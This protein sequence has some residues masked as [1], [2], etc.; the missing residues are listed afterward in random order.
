MATLFPAVSFHRRHC[1]AAWTSESGAPGAEQT[2]GGGREFC[3]E[4]RSRLIAVSATDFVL[5]TP[6]AIGFHRST[7]N[8]WERRRMKTKDYYAILGVSRNE[9]ANGIKAAFRRLAKSHHPD[10]AG[11][12]KT[13]E[14]Q[15]I[16]EA[17]C[18]L[19][20]PE[21]RRHYD[22]V[23]DAAK[24]SEDLRV[25]R[26]NHV[27]LRPSRGRRT[28]PAPLAAARGPGEELDYRLW[29]EFR[30]GLS[31]SGLFAGFIQERLRQ[32]PDVELILTAEEA[33][34]GG[35]LVVPFIYLCPRCEGG[36]FSLFS[37]CAYCAGRGMINS[38]KS[39]QVRIPPSIEDQT[40]LSIP[41]KAPHTGRASFNVWVCIES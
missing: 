35:F 14:F 3:D 11:F 32:R 34:R 41:V 25:E 24:Q 9:S 40:L 23:L 7:L 6:Y 26:K 16:T 20:N 19:S 12:A 15:E 4:A 5:F 31:A 36:G 27:S 33:S 21:D 1:Q 22:D 10:V 2:R 8:D 28:K 37:Q 30:Q 13:S 17:Y 29:Q 39:I 38:G 18:V